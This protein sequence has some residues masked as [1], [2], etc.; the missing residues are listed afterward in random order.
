V[1]V[2]AGRFLLPVTISFEG[3]ASGTTVDTLYQPGVTFRAITNG[4]DGGLSGLPQHVYAVLD[5]TTARDGGTCLPTLCPPGGNVVSLNP[6]LPWYQ[7]A[8]GGIQATFASPKAWV[9]IVS[10]P[11]LLPETAGNVINEP[12][13]VAYG[14]SGNYLGEA[15]YPFPKSDSRWGTF[16]TIQFNAPTG[17]TIG[18]VIFSTQQR[19]GAPVIAEFD[20]LSYPQ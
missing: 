18:S 2:S 12:Y 17:Q 6:Q 15:L 8:T 13:L 11:S 10:R 4:A 1:P 9:S 14:P 20:N 3:V 19:G 5:A 16:Q 7:G